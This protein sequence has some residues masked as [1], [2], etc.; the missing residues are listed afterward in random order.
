[1]IKTKRIIPTL[2][3]ED[4]LLY[5]TVKFKSPNYVGDPINAIKIFNDKEVDELVVL[6]ITA[7]RKKTGPNFELLSE[8]ASECFMPLA[9]GGG[10]STIEHF[11]RL[12]EIGIEKVSVNELFFSNRELLKDVINRYGA[13]SLVITLDVIK[14]FFGD[15]KVSNTKD[16]L[17]K[18]LHDIDT[19]G[20]GELMINTVD[21]EG[22]FKGFDLELLQKV[23][24]EVSVPTIMCGGAS[25][26]NDFKAAFDAG[27]SAVAAG[28]FFVYVGKHKAVLITYPSQV[29]INQIFEK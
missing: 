23:I 7:D 3:I 25:S 19:L 12:F 10:V 27:A 28:S 2:L 1:M 21:R 9:Y 6:D 18:V 11:E 13:Q 24:N 16:S 14:P 5:K 15:Y 22:T 29:E 26:M 20:V 8:I 17:I 4:G